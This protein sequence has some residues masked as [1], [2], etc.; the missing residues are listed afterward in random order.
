MRSDTLS[1]PFIRIFRPMLKL[2]RCVA[3]LEN[4]EM[5][6]RSVASV[7]AGITVYHTCE[8]SPERNRIAVY[9]GCQ[10]EVHLPGIVIEVITD[11]TW[12]D[13]IIGT[14]QRALKDSLVR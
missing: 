6:V 13:D 12:V 10:F 8:D 7:G 14:I 1:H 4:C 2:V 5:I 9:R 3:A 11:E